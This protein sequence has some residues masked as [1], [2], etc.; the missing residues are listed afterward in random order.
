MKKIIL[1][2]IIAF[3]ILSCSKSDSDCD[4]KRAEINVYYDKQIKYAKDNPEGPNGIYGVNY[5]K[6]GLLEQER[7]KKLSESCK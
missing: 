5:R 4:S 2:S 7:Q 6:I 1:T 3:S